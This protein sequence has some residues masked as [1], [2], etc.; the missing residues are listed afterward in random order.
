MF[1]SSFA[2]CSQDVHA[3]NDNVISIDHMENL[4]WEVY[5]DSGENCSV[6][7]S[8]ADGELPNSAG[9]KVSY[10]FKENNTWVGIYKRINLGDFPPLDG[11]KFRYYGSGAP[12]SIELKLVDNRGRTFGHICS[13]AT[14]TE[15][16][17]SVEASER[18]IKYWWGGKPLSSDEHI[19]LSDVEEIHFA[20]SNKKEGDTLGGG[21]VI[22]DE[23][24]GIKKQIPPNTFEKYKDII[25]KIIEGIFLLLAGLIGYLI[26]SRKD[27]NTDHDYQHQNET[28]IRSSDKNNRMTK[29]KFNVFV[30][31]NKEGYYVATIPDI[32]GFR[33]QAKSF[34]EVIERAKETIESCKKVDDKD[35]K[36]ALSEFVGVQ[37]IEA[38]I[39]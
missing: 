24:E 23:V 7:L 30:E 2:I 16:W 29:L 11:L 26:R 17:R 9:V 6:E 1:V 27:D 13:C 28:K 10:E 3:Q 5:N 36:I 33:N 34:D 35:I 38:E 20:I 32:P 19:G 4:R 14:A 25:I 22:I 37:V 18:D 39:G 21:Y 31:R 15:G 8:M 12:N